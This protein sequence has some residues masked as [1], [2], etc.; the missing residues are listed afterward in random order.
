MII[1]E[2]LKLFSKKI[3]A[4]RLEKGLKDVDAIEEQEVSFEIVL[5]KSDSRAKWFK[6]GKIIYPDQK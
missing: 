5:T 4:L 6:D 3:A 1:N 2:F